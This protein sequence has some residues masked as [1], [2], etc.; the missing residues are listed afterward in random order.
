MAANS[1][2]EK[3]RQAESWICTLGGVIADWSTCFYQYTNRL[4][5]LYLL[6]ELNKLPAYLV[7]LYFVKD[8][9]MNG[10]KMYTEWE[11]AIQLLELFLG[12]RNHNLSRFV[13]HA[14][15]DVH[16]LGASFKNSI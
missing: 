11:A 7:F 6:R 4:A 2:L 15:V 1:S 9:E 12:V 13:L 5:H 16:E 3:P 8:E 10:P 14:F